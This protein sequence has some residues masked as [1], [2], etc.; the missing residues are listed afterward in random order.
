[1]IIAASL[2]R[3]QQE[4]IAH[5]LEV[6]RPVH[7]ICELCTVDA[8]MRVGIG[9]YT[10]VTSVVGRGAGFGELQ[11]GGALLGRGN[12]LGRPGPGTRVGGSRL[13][14]DARVG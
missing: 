3:E 1:M 14:G 12:V 13:G 7:T 11:I 4:V 9:L 2:T 8:G 6:H 10:E 5:I